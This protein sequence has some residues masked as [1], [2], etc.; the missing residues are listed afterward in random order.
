MRDVS[1][2]IGRFST[3]KDQIIFAEPQPILHVSAHSLQKTCSSGPETS[4]VIRRHKQ[5]G[6][7]FGLKK[8]LDLLA[9]RTPSAL[10]AIKEIRLPFDPARHCHSEEGI[11]AENV[12]RRKHPYEVRPPAGT[13][14]RDYV[15][16]S[17]CLPDRD[18][19]LL[20]QF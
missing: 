13:C 19:Y 20:A 17:A 5:I 16:E 6:G 2:A 10:V 9:D 12:P 8:G 18:T 7:P 4:N 15:H 14:S 3:A 1:N 11:A